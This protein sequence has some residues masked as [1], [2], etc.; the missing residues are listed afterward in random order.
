MTRSAALAI[1]ALTL[2]APHGVR[3]EP[4]DQPP[5][6][7]PSGATLVV[8]TGGP[9]VPGGAGVACADDRRWF[10]GSLMDLFGLRASMTRTSDR[11]PTWGVTVVSEGSVYGAGHIA[12]VRMGHFAMLGV[13]PDGV[14]GGIGADYALGV[15]VPLGRHHGPLARLGL[16]GHLLGDS[17]LYSSMIELPELQLGYQLLDKHVH[18]EIAGRGGAVLVGR[19]NAGDGRRKLGNAP[20]YGGYAT[21]RW[22]DV[23]LELDA[24]RVALR[25]RTPVDS[26]AGRLCG[27]ASPVGLCLDARFYRGDVQ[28]DAGGTR[29][30]RS[31]YLGFA[32]GGAL[33]E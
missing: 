10:E 30:V 19:Y 11:T 31:V 24:T 16:R 13:G 32:V 26:L 7:G 3:A 20:E 33:R 12:N 18:L 29:A 2:L 17:E 8:A 21:L 27:V 5:R 15:R 9:C 28:L 1:V 14:E 6:S 23:Q 22:E 25:S 4:A